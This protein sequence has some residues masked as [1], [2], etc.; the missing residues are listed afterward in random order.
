MLYKSKRMWGQRDSLSTVTASNPFIPAG[1]GVVPYSKGRIV[2]HPFV[3]LSVDCDAPLVTAICNW[4][5]WASINL[6]VE[7]C[8]SEK[9]PIRLFVSHLFAEDADYLR[10]FEFLESVDRFFYIN[11]SKPEAIPQSGGLEA[12]KDEF[13]AQIKEAEA[14]VVLATHF[15]EN[16]E[17]VEFQMDVAEAHETPIIVIRPFGGLKET[18]DE[19]VQRVKEHAVWNDREIADAIRRQARLEDTARWDVIDFP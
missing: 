4:I 8:V 16:K 19:L 7:T 3:M 6:A 1:F 12:I 13:I 15:D 17:L 2:E 9:N 18:A 14:V 10:V 11:V 5:N